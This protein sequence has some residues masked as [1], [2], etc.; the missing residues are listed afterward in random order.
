MR[1][2][3]FALTS[4]IAASGCGHES[5]T[6]LP[7]GL[8]Q[9]PVLPFPTDAI[10]QP[11]PTTPTG[12]R[13][14]LDD[15]GKNLGDVD[16]S[17]FL[18]GDDFA[19]AFANVDGWSVLGPAFVQVP[20]DADMTTIEDHLVL[21]DLEANAIV[22]TVKDSF[23][24]KTEDGRP[25]HFISA[26][27]RTPLQPK[28]KHAIVLLAGARGVSK[29]PFARPALFDQ[30]LRGEDPSRIPGD[31]DRIRLA[32]ARLQ[33]LKDALSTLRIKADDVL[34]ADTYTTE[35]V[36]EETN[37][38]TAAYRAQ[39]PPTID[40][41]PDGDGVP[42]VYPKPSDDPKWEGPKDEDDSGIAR[43]VRF[44]IQVPSFRKTP[45]GPLVVDAMQAVL[46]GSEKV[47]GLFILP[48]GSGPFP[49]V[50]FQHGLG[51]HKESVWRFAPGFAK[52]GLATIAFDAPLHGT[53]TDSPKT[54][55]TEF[56][57]ITN[58][59]VVVDNFRQGEAE[60]V[61]LVQAIDAMAKLDLLGSRSRPIDPSLLFWVGHSLGSMIGAAAIGLEPRYQGAVLIVGGGTLL[62][63]LDRILGGLGLHEFPGEL[64]ATVAQTALDRGDPTNYAPLSTNKEVLLMQGMEDEVMPAKATESLARAL[65]LPQVEPIYMRADDM[66][67]APVP[68]ETRGWTQWDP[69][70]HS[71]VYD[72]P[73]YP[74]AR[75]Q[76]LH[77][78]T[79]WS[80]ARTAEIE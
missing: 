30:V 5:G 35:S 54:A 17:L 7:Y 14:H 38:L 26:Q 8:T 65:R 27:P 3:A 34:V 23:G 29:K 12:F 62:E 80:T 53:R 36:F 72:V 42:N 57:D 33:P 74:Q 78:L 10:L 59:S 1:R 44:S 31:P 47:E 69:A 77:F 66:E 18:F 32:E 2:L 9:R 45:R 73:T 40:L 50:T 28:T 20:E 4:I 22:R 61:Y 51:D 76:M 19:A 25:L 49:V 37:V 15:Q 52:I 6:P 58:P 60:R 43:L 63:F 41:D 13:M 64:F 67:D 24:G 39:P 56:I 46:Q 16:E 48:K 11:D 68:A 79:T 21:I 75:A 71:L 70:T 55:A